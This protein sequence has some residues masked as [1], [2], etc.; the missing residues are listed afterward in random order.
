MDFH[1][2]AFPRHYSL[3]QCLSSKESK[4]IHL[5]VPVYSTVLSRI[6]SRQLHNMAI[7]MLDGGGETIQSLVTIYISFAYFEQKSE[8]GQ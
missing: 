8:K 3:Q 4:N 5:Q 1:G 7:Q 6:R 2:S